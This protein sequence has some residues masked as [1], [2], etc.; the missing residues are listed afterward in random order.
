MLP[1]YDM[2]MKAQN[3]RTA[4]LLARQVNLTR[5]QGELAL[6][7]LLPAFS[8]ALKR[9]TADPFGFSQF[10]SAMG[11]GQYAK[12]FEDAARA[13][14]PEGIAAGNDALGQIF[15]SKELSRA[16]AAQAAQATGIAQ[17]AY[18]QMMPALAAMMMG[19]FFKQ[20]TGQMPGAGSNPFIEAFQKMMPQAQPANAG[21]FDN[22]YAKMMQDMFAPKADAK[23][24]A[25]PDPYAHNPFM[26]MFE[27]MMQM[28]QPEAKAPQDR[29]TD[30]SV[31][32]F[33]NFFGEMFETGRKQ[34]EDY[35]KAMT[36]LVDDFF[37]QGRA[38]P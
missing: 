7:T 25:A 24:K 2:M 36:K 31:F 11:G 19:G 6:E 5:Q 1:L 33:E 15:G 17:E 4:D 21:M 26:K 23:P 9:N 13:F 14:T 18:R 37:A 30:A 12:Y 10:M 34:Q 20:A 22:P 3:G 28:G 27:D 16:V 32:P 29:F 8:E 38:S 35:Q